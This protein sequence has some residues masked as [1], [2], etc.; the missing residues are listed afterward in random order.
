MKLDSSFVTYQWWCGGPYVAHS[1]VPAATLLNGAPEQSA[2]EVLAE[3]PRNAETLLFHINCTST[4]DFPHRR[5]ELIAALEKRNVRMLNQHVVDISKRNVQQTCERLGL[6]AV[7][8]GPDEGDP[9]EVLIVKT[10]SNAAGDSEYQLDGN[11]RAQL[12]LPEP[13]ANLRYAQDYRVQPRKTIP[14]AWWKDPALAIERFVSNP[15]GVWFRAYFLLN[16]M[17][18]VELQSADD[19]KKVGGSAVLSTT[20][21]SLSGET[22]NAKQASPLPPALL[23]HLGKFIAGFA[24]DFGTIDVMVNQKAVAFIVDVNSTPAYRHKVPGLVRFLRLAAKD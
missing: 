2:A 17:V 13:P 15:K 5:P 11:R 24:I 10:N 9:N 18:V 6:P 4:I 16:R 7:R 1:L 8:T 21:C 22:W 19:I 3:V 23:A 20:A 12:G 14:D